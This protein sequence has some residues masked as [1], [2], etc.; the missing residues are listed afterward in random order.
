MIALAW[1][2]WPTPRTLQ[3]E[4]RHRCLCPRSAAKWLTPP[5]ASTNRCFLCR[6][7]RRINPSHPIWRQRRRPCGQ[8]RPAIR[9]LA[10]PLLEAAPRPVLR[11]IHQSCSQ[12]IAFNVTVHRQQVLVGFDH[13]RLEPALVK[14]ACP[15]A[16]P[17]SV[18]FFSRRWRYLNSGKLKVT[19]RTVSKEFG[20]PFHA[21]RSPCP[22]VHRQKQ[23]QQNCCRDQQQE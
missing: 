12:R 11:T 14:M 7:L 4:G 15:S 17:E 13:E 19:K 5:S 21:P 3:S 6:G 23:E 16:A 10:Q 18:P 1:S 2:A 20:R 9:V 8:H 22:W